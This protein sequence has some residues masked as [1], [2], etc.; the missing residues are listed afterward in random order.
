MA[1]IVEQSLEQVLPAVEARRHRL[2]LTLPETPAF[3]LGDPEVAGPGGRRT[4]PAS[5]ITWSGRS[6]P[7]S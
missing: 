4:R 7:R 5:T 6:T 3:I 1:S 2:A